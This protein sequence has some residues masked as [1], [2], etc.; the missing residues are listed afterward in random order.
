VS[1]QRVGI[2]PYGRPPKISV[3]IVRDH[4]IYVESAFSNNSKDN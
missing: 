3:R 2:E 4:T 1:V